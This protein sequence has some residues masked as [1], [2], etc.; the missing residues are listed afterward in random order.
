MGASTRICVGRPGTFDPSAHERTHTLGVMSYRRGMR[1]ILGALTVTCIA[2]SD[3]SPP[4][5]VVDAAPDAFD[6]SRCLIKGNYGALG[7]LT[8]TRAMTA[9]ATTATMTLD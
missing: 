5:V 1:I 6:T 2:C 8:G 4:T 7:S 9:T 3:S